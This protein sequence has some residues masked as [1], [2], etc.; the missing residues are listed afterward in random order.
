MTR[1]LLVACLL[2]PTLLCGQSSRSRNQIIHYLA[3]IT[4]TGRNRVVVDGVAV[5]LISQ[6]ASPEGELR[7]NGL[8]FE[9]LPVSFFT[10]FGSMFTTMGNITDTDYYAEASSI[11]T[12]IHGFSFSGGLFEGVEMNGMSWNFFNSYAS[13]SHG[14]EVTGFMNSNY[15]FSGAQL[16][17]WGNRAIQ[18]RGFQFGSFN[19]C[20]DCKVIQIGFLNRIGKRVL[21]II[22]FDLKRRSKR[23]KSNPKLLS[24]STMITNQIR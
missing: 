24:K 21:P 2:V 10:T 1:S 22:N 11:S 4:P 19:S 12:E 7:I 13:N 15:S 6:P 23:P 17:I 20:E 9:V 3:W 16:S 18:G 8:N 5:G 14:L